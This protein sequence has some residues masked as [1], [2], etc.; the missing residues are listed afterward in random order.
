[1]DDEFRAWLRTNRDERTR[2]SERVDQLDAEL[3]ERVKQ[4]LDE[5]IATAAEVAD[6]LGVSRARVYQIRDGRR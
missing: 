6:A 5:R 2:A 3:T 4:A 1:M